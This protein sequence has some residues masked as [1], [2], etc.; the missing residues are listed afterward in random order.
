M[1]LF[2]IAAPG[3]EPIVARELERLGETPFI[4]D[5]GVTW[6]GD[7]ASMMSANLWLRAASRV[8]VRVASFRATAFYELEKR[9]KRIAWSQFVAP[10]QAASF[11]VTARKSKLYHSDAIAERLELHVPYLR[12]GVVL[13]SFGTRY[14]RVPGSA[15]SVVKR[16]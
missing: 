11:R 1:K 10:G 2:A 5:G 6:E 4:E 3:L 7:A 12:G 9:A 14:L 13:E 16:R 15:F 8:V